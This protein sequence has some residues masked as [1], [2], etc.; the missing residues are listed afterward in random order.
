VTVGVAIRE[1][2]EALAATSDTP[3]LDA[4]LLVAALLG[5]TRSEM[6]LRHMGD[7]VPTGIGSVVARRMR[8]EPVAYILG[9][10]EFYGRVF[11][12]EPG[13]LIPRADS[14]TVVAAALEACP[15]PRRVLDLGVGSGALLLTVLAERPG[16]SGIGVDRSAKALEVA[17]ANAADLGLPAEMRPADWTQAGWADRLGTFDLILAN[18]PYVEEHADLAADVRDHE[19]AEALFAGPEGLD[20]YR[21]LVPQLSALLIPGGVAVLEIGHAQA[22]AVA[23]IAARAGFAS[24]M[25]RDLGRRPRAVILRRA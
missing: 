18:P 21:V 12:V 15:A 2:A 25:R 4:E 5:V 23:A 8:H 24:E 16:A 10:T 11:A 1:A 22:D 17:R 19:P 14:E 3:R 7:E 9:E 13:V 20:D 6:L